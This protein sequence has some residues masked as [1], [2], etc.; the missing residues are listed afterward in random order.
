[1]GLE[2]RFLR[3][4]DRIAK[5]GG[6]WEWPLAPNTPGYGHF[7]FNGKTYQAHRAS[8][9]VNVGP[10]P[11]GLCVLHTCDNRLCVRPDHLWLG[12]KT[13]NMRDMIAKGRKRGGPRPGEAHHSAK[14]SDADVAAIRAS[15]DS[16]T[17][18]A[19]RYG[20]HQSHISRI[21]SGDT[22]VA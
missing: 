17:A 2:Q 13:D 21:K 10:I 5:G 4:Y 1:M 14:L 11:D 3:H 18:L 16:Q 22:R 15:T 19:R 9:E 6:C 8:Y 7:R 20:V 12:T